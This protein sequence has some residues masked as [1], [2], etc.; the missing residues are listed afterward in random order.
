MPPFFFFFFMATGFAF[1]GAERA[2]PGVAR[3]AAGGLASDAL[4]GSPPYAT[5]R[6]HKPVSS[7]TVIRILF[8][9]LS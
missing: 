4:G 2:S 5:A 8:I 3:V 6:P 1:I 9:P 7:P